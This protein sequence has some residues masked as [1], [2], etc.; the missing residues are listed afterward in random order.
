MNAASGNAAGGPASARAS[1]GLRLALNFVAFQ[2]GWFACVLGAARGAPLLGPAVCAL[3][4]LAML[5][6]S[7][8]R[9]A[10]LLLLLAGGLVGGAWDTLLSVLG[11]FRF[12]T[13]HHAPLLPLW[14]LALWLIFAS[15]CNSSLRWL[16]GRA[17]LAAALAAV[18]APLSYLA[19]QRLGA[20]AMPQPA[21][22]LGAQALGW[23]LIL[24]LLLHL[25]RRLDA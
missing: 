14:M 10:F 15:T 12:D 24:P 19:G 17:L 1:G 13:A 11:L 20:L 4:L 5:W 22:A 7:R 8:R 23:A 3:L 2:A 6:A 9:R 25:A 21:L 18:A 16:Q